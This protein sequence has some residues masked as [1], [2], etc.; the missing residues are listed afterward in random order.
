MFASDYSVAVEDTNAVSIG[1]KGGSGSN[2]DK[3]S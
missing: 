2:E 1:C 3:P